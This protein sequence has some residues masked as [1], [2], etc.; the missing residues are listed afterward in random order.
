[1]GLIV[2]ER[3]KFL[4]ARRIRSPTGEIPFCRAQVFVHER[5][6]AAGELLV[7]LGKRLDACDARLKEV[8][9]V[10]QRFEDRR[11]GVSVRQHRAAEHQR[12]CALRGNTHAVCLD[13][14]AHAGAAIDGLDVRAVVRSGGA[15]AFT[16]VR[17][18]LGESVLGGGR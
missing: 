7:P 15:S 6:R 11:P 18:G 12:R 5:M 3:E 10:E 8:L 17:A 1:M 13:Q 16:E 14:A 4:A 2:H 9:L